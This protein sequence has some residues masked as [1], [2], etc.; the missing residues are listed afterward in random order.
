MLIVNGKPIKSFTFPGGERGVNVGENFYPVLRLNFQS[1]DDIVDLIL[2]VDALRERFGESISLTLD[3][4]YFPYARQDRVCNGGE[5]FS[6]RAI[7]KLISNLNFKQVRVLDPH[8]DVLA[9]LFDSG[10]LRIIPQEE[11][12]KATLVNSGKENLAFDLVSPDGGALKKIIKVANAWNN[13]SLLTSVEN[14]SQIIYANKVRDVS[15]GEILKTDVINPTDSNN[16]YLMI[17][18]DICDGGRT[19]IELAKVIKSTPNLAHK[20]IGL[21]VTHGIF[22]KGLNVF[23]GYIDD[24]FCHNPMNYSDLFVNGYYSVNCKVKG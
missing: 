3:I 12:F 10:V 4:P 18:D 13:Y 19:F 11:L 2:V 15:T 24:I 8:S 22:S 1:S 23:E 16:G 9:G 21:Y 7:A 5:S 20:K 6:L 17:V 14:K